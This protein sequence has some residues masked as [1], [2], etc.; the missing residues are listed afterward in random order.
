VEVR[1]GFFKGIVR[2]VLV[3]LTVTMWAH[4]PCLLAA[5]CGC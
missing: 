4:N 2:S 3:D 5:M 1:V